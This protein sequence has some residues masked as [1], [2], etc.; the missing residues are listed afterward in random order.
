MATW[1]VDKGLARLISEWKAA[2][3]GAVV[4]TI[5]DDDHKGGPSDHNPEADG[6][7]DAADFMP[8]RGGVTMADLWELRDGL[9]RS[10]DR[11][12]LYAI[13]GQEIVSSV[14]APW[15]P[16]PYGG[17]RH[18]HLHVSVNDKYESDGSDWKWETMA[19]R[20]YTFTEMDVRLPNLM[21]GDE[22]TVTSYISRAQRILKV[23]D[24][25]VYGPDTAAAVKKWMT[26]KTATTTN[27]T[28]IGEPE[29]RSLYALGQG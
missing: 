7:V 5:G 26:G 4:Y 13:I 15:T 23:E 21:V 27:G 29:W 9:V 25:G 20:E 18:A 2:H 3:P 8:D 24:D 17:K 11:R 1:H 28:K 12:F 10:R 14:V 19:G 22:D 16:R 6:S